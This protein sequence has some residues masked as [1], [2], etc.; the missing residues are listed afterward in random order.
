MPWQRSL[1]PSLLSRFQ[2]LLHL[3]LHTGSQA[4]SLLFLSLSYPILVLSCPS[5]SLFC[6]SLNPDLRS[7]ITTPFGGPRKHQRLCRSDP[8][9][10]L[11][12]VIYLMVMPLA[13][14]IKVERCNCSPESL[15]ASGFI[16]W[17]SCLTRDL[18]QFQAI[19]THCQ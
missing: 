1:L 5:P 14:S 19:S 13:R 18:V 16:A 15:S 9:C 3:H 10:F 4:A 7:D 6:F 8:V 12:P 2:F 17:R 11:L